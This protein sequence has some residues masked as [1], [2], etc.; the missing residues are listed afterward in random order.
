MWPNPLHIVTLTRSATRTTSPWCYWSTRYNTQVTLYRPLFLS[1]TS[2]QTLFLDYIR[3]ICVILDPALRQM[4]DDVS[5][6]RAVGWGISAA[7]NKT[8]RVLQTLNMKRSEN[9]NC[10]LKYKRTLSR[11]QICVSGGAPNTNLCN[12]DS[13]GPVGNYIQI[14]PG[15][16]SPQFV[17]IGIASYIDHMCENTTPLTDVLSHGDWI[18]RVALKYTPKENITEN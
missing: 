2:I 9:Q 4:V 18:Y 5:T 17:Q 15:K 12:G 13:G 14:T 3:P 8:S 16:G 10:A 6:L 1:P 11:S 7:N